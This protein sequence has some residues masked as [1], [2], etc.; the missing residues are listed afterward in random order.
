[1]EPNCLQALVNEIEKSNTDLVFSDMEFI[2]VNGI[3]K[4][5]KWFERH[6]KISEEKII[7]SYFFSGVNPLPYPSSLIRKSVISNTDLCK[8]ITQMADMYMWASILLNG[9]K[10]SY[11]DTSLVKYR[12]HE[13]Q[14]SSNSNAFIYS[15]SMFEAGFLADLFLS[16]KN[17]NLLGC[18]FDLPECIKYNNITCE[19]DIFFI[20]AYNLSKSKIYTYKL[21]A[22]YKLGYLINKNHNRLI[23]NNTFSIKEYRDLYTYEMTHKTS[24]NDLIFILKKLIFGEKKTK[25]KELDVV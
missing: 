4:N 9:G 16:C 22:L 2:D 19:D 20:N 8:C 11:L 1:M 14:L 18:V 21:K 6:E 5:K 24:I 12:I 3:N 10:I 17:I 23:N 25:I 7:K 13:G 15:R